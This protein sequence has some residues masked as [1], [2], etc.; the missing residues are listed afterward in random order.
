MWRPAHGAPAL[1][2]ARM[3]KQVSTGAP[4]GRRRVFP[5]LTCAPGG[6]PRCAADTDA[7]QTRKLRGGF[8]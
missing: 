4:D 6:M 3:G 2:Q 1:A 7:T 5:Q 8:S